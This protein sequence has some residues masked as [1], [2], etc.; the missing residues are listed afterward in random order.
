MTAI[1]SLR[2]TVSPI[3]AAVAAGLSRE[4]KSL[5]PHLFYDAEGSRLFEEITALPEY[6][7]TRTER[8]ILETNAKDM[9][10]QAGPSLSL[11]ELGAGTA[12]KTGILI[13]ALLQRQLR[14][15]FCPIDVCPDVLESARHRL[16]AEFPGLKVHPLAADYTDGFAGLPAMPGRKLVL[17]LGSSIGNFEPDAATSVLRNLRSRLTEGD[18]LLLGTDLEKSPALLLPAYDDSLGVTARFNKNMLL[19]INRELGGHF[20]HDDFRHTVRWNPGASRIE[21]YL[22]SIRDHVVRIDALNLIVRFRA[23]ESI[24]TE[25]SYKYKRS[26]IDTILIRGGFRPERTW[27]DARG[28]FALHLARV[29]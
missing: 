27:T 9:L 25:N 21:I 8:S 3:G 20:N 11:V 14:V 2:Q 16:A 1:E 23:G 26:M 28:W 4:P 10:A 12:E 29:S 6:Y 15:H 7:L 5:P 24:H 17:Y 19:R 13:R 22:Q 18:C